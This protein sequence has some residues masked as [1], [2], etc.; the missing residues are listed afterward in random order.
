MMASNG[1]K[2]RAVKIFT[3][4]K[5]FRHE[6]TTEELK[7]VTKGKQSLCSSFTKDHNKT[8]IPETCVHTAAAVPQDVTVN[9]QI[10]LVSQEDTIKQV[11]LVELC[12]RGH[13][14]P[15]RCDDE[16]VHFWT[17]FL[18]QKITIEQRFL[19]VE[20]TRVTQFHRVSE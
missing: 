6:L 3:Q 19:R 1:N 16:K 18:S 4:G 12:T 14:S 17:S 8:M 2:L 9:S 10:T 20:C 7:E 15:T 5:S 13:S 11:F